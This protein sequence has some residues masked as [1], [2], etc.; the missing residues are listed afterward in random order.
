MRTRTT[1]RTFK[2]KL[3]HFHK[4]KLTY[5]FSFRETPSTQYQPGITLPALAG[6]YK[7]LLCYLIIQGGWWVRWWLCV[8]TRSHVYCSMCLLCRCLCS[9]PG[10][11][12][13]SRPTGFLRR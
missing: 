2:G 7:A 6:C 4:R 12:F 8:S 10:A 5:G 11:S 3:L 13:Y 1:T 9:L